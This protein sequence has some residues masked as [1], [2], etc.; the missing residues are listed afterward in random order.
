MDNYD[1]YVSAE[2]AQGLIDNVIKFHKTMGR[3]VRGARKGTSPVIKEHRFFNLYVSTQPPCAVIPLDKR[4]SI[5]QHRLQE[6]IGFNLAQNQ[7]A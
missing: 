1:I 6:L 5:F 3:K 2:D 7:I 4:V